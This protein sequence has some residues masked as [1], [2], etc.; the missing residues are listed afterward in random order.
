MRPVRSLRAP[1]SCLD[2]GPAARGVQVATL[3]LS[4]LVLLGAC[5]AD[6]PAEPEAEA[7]PELF[8]NLT[9]GWNVVEP[10]GETT[11]SDGSDYRFF[12]RKGDPAK[13][14]VYLQGGGGC[15]NAATCDREGQPTYTTQ[16]P[17]QLK[18]PAGADPEEGAVHG[19]LAFGHPENPFA[20]YSVLFVPYCTG[21]VHIGNRSASY[22]VAADGDAPERE[23]TVEHK[24]FVNGM[25]ALEWAYE[26]F[27]SP[28]TIFVTGSSAGA[29]P[30]PA[31]ARILKDH[32]GAARVV[33]L[34][35]GAGGYRNIAN[36]RPHE[37]WDALAALSDFPEIAAM[38]SE[39]FSF[40]ALYTTAGAAE[41]E[42]MFSR[43]DTAEDAVQVQ[44]LAIS[45]Q[46][47]ESLQT[48]LDA[49]EADIDAAITNY[50]S[51]LAP[52]DVHTILLRPEFYTYSVDGT[53]FRDWIADLAAGNPV[54]DVHCGECTGDPAPE[55]LLSGATGAA[56]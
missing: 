43:Y 15:W 33:Q 47:P 28:E 17:P 10:G 35:D 21:D 48:L 56:P 54:D 55:A 34:G 5:Q 25:A 30:S 53:R 39:D 31:Y 40:E 8:A 46:A 26:A 24:G 2:T 18:S 36:A 9:D 20:D 19:V 52:G 22:T 41:P 32:Y 29:I 16:A 38:S 3:L 49:N 11:C 6:A 23:V 1:S 50:R 14:M 7:P 44:F 37:A 13:L 45:G 42:V 51:Y 4:L 27:R 12:A